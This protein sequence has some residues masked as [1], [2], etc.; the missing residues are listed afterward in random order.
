[1]T[2]Q[3]WLNELAEDPEH[4]EVWAIFADWLE[5]RGDRRADA[6]CWAIE[7][8]KFPSYAVSIHFLDEVYSYDWWRSLEHKN[9]SNCDI[10]LDIFGRLRCRYKIESQLMVREY[11]TKQE[12]I[13]AVFNAYVE[14]ADVETQCV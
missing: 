2:E 9:E 6:V 14:A 3:Q 10:P 13:Q 12:A 4:G 7:N 1:M 8:R 11:L 5:D